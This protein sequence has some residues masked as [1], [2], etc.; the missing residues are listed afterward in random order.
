MPRS[1]PAR[2]APSSRRRD[3][4]RRC[5][6]AA[7]A[8]RGSAGRRR[9][10][11]A[12][13]GSPWAGCWGW[14]PCPRWSP[15]ARARRRAAGS[16]PAGR[17]C[18]GAADRRTAPST[19]ALST[20]LPAYITSTSSATSAITPRSWVMI[21]IAMPSRFCRSAQ[22]VE[23]LRLDGDVERRGRL[24]GDQQRGLAG[25]R[26]GDHDAL[27]H[28]ARQAVRI[29][30]D[31]LGRRGDAHQLEHLDG[32]LLGRL[33]R[34]A[35]CAP[36]SPRRSAGRSCGPGSA[37]SSAPGRSSTSCRRAGGGARRPRG[38]ARRGRRTCTASASTWP[39]GLA[40]R[41]MTESEVTLLPQPEFAHQADGL[42]AVDGEVD[43]VDRAEQAAVGMEVRPKTADLEKLVHQNE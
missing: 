29:V 32:A 42:A 13:S 22:Q 3:G 35:A 1:S 8:P 21:R 17:S 31:A 33:R 40:T 39:G 30:V 7:A 20:I 36:G 38:R 5:R 6:A 27:A 4:R 25:Q 12:R 26:H 10:S 19:G 9:G 14:A 23:D 28:A 41:P 24:V 43:A 18:R 11:A 2:P 16:S 34:H 15:A 37:R